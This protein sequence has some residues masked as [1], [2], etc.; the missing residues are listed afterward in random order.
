MFESK[1]IGRGVS[2]ATGGTIGYLVNRIQPER[3]P[4]DVLGFFLKAS[5]C[6]FLG[7]YAVEN[8]NEVVLRSV[9]GYMAY[10]SVRS[11]PYGKVT[12]KD[13]SGLY[14][15]DIQQ[16]SQPQTAMVPYGQNYNQR[17][18]PLSEVLTP[19]NLE[20]V[21][22]ALKGISSLFNGFRGTPPGK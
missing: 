22:Y 18:N 16:Q 1:N 14:G 15:Y 10:E 20:N 21:G 6:Y 9:L 19:E 17:Q 3:Q 4:A 5:A 2:V 12:S 11:L 13:P 7:Q 8:E